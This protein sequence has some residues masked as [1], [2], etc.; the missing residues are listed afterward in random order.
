VGVSGKGIENRRTYLQPVSDIGNSEWTHFQLVKNLRPFL[1]SR[2]RARGRGRASAVTGPARAGFGP[3][4]F[5]YFL[6]LFH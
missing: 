6:F 4:L 5:I 2:H 1:Q 3:R